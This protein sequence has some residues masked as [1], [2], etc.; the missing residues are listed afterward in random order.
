MIL[1]CQYCKQEFEA[2]RRDTKYC[3]RKCQY[4]ANRQNKKDGVYVNIK[5]CPKCNKQFVIQ[6]NGFNRRYCYDCVPQTPKSGAENRRLIK[7]W[8]L[9]YKGNKCICCGYNACPDALDFHHLNEEEKEFQL[10]NR[11]LVLD[12]EK[13]KI[14]LD[15]CILVCS[16]CHRE[17]HAGYR[18]LEGEKYELQ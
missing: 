15:K 10:S 4:T 5:I 17:I 14:E 8:A 1:I 2:K 18:S 16:N 12:W 13:I 9:E 11:N 6:D 3:C 7:K